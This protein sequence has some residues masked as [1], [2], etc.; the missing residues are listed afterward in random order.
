[1]DAPLVRIAVA[2]FL[3][4]AVPAS[5]GERLSGRAHVTDGDTIRHYGANSPR[6]I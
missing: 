6:Q 5:A 3:A 1:M 2:L 4:L